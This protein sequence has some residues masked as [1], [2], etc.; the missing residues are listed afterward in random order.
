V[1]NKT[2][3]NCKLSF[4]LFDQGYSNMEIVDKKAIFNR[5][6]LPVGLRSIQ[7]W[8]KL[9]SDD[10]DYDSGRMSNASSF[11]LN[12]VVALMENPK[13]FD[14][15]GYRVSKRYYGLKEQK[16]KYVKDVDCKH[17]QWRNE[18]LASIVIRRSDYTCSECGNHFNLEAHHFRNEGSFD[19]DDC[20]CLCRGCHGKIPKNNIV[21]SK[22]GDSK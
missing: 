17:K 16:E 5:S 12:E 11:T 13:L 7:Y 10:N 22:N 1:Q 20:I 21:K 3:D 14:E 8:R 19:P 4:E 6:G 9:W 2:L 18:G 15:I